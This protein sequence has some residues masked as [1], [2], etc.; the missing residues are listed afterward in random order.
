MF[1]CAVD[2]PDGGSGSIT[3][4]GDVPSS[5]PTQNPTSPSPL[6]Q[7]HTVATSASG[8]NSS[9]MKA[10]DSNVQADIHRA[11]RDTESNAV[12]RWSPLWYC[13]DK[14][15]VSERKANAA[16]MCGSVGHPSIGEEGGVSRG[17]TLELFSSV[18]R[19][20]MPPRTATESSW[21]LA[22]STATAPAAVNCTEATKRDAA[23]SED[24][25]AAAVAAPA[26]D[27]PADVAAAAAAAAADKTAKAA[28][29][30]GAAP[31]GKVF[32]STVPADLTERRS[33]STGAIVRATSGS[34][35]ALLCTSSEPNLSGAQTHTITSLA[36][37]PST[38]TNASSPP[39]M[40][41]VPPPALPPIRITH[42]N[43]TFAPSATSAC[44]SSPCMSQDA[45]RSAGVYQ[46][47]QSYAL[48]PPVFF[49][50]ATSSLKLQ[51]QQN[52]QISA[53]T[54]SYPFPHALPSS[55]NET[56]T[57]CTSV[58]PTHSQIQT[59]IQNEADKQGLA[60]EDQNLSDIMPPKHTS[61]NLRDSGTWR[62]PSNGD[63][64]LPLH[65]ITPEHA[66][67][68]MNSSSP[69]TLN[70]ESARTPSPNAWPGGQDSYMHATPQLQ[71][72]EAQLQRHEDSE[73][74]NV[75]DKQIAS[76]VVSRLSKVRNA[77]RS[78]RWC[79]SVC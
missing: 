19:A 74:K 72:P 62:E 37:P 35:S 48:P 17:G 36:R 78:L 7:Q 39:S 21:S 43:P 8:D 22:T 3:I 76:T 77:L 20:C 57:I 45:A 40:P 60:A 25:H 52:S 54:S 30:G 49:S 24:V 2:S 56:S 61:L 58:A 70:V 50:P 4:C 68:G 10:I 46:D 64:A 26:A 29:A 41:L 75:G 14:D 33:T 16:P 63:K 79:S 51:G 69:A 53:R 11:K 55:I 42:A 67:V 27:A 44:M 18:M 73:Q 15:Y 31:T 6:S 13:W 32:S 12:N 38:P 59:Q 28:P 66:C 9:I 5:H 23:A 47:S 65:E 34:G 71:R 1:V